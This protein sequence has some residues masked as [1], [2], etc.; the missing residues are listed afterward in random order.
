MSMSVPLANYDLLG[1]DFDLTSEF[2]PAPPPYLPK[3]ALP[4]YKF[5]PV[6]YP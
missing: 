3:S 6:R 2:K 1:G 5:K 4:E